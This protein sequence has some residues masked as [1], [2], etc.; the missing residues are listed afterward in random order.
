MGVFEAHKF[1]GQTTGLTRCWC[2][3]PSRKGVT[4]QDVTFECNNVPRRIYRFILPWMKRDLQPQLREYIVLGNQNGSPTSLRWSK[5]ITGYAGMARR[6]C[7]FN[8]R[9]LSSSATAVSKL[10][11]GGCF[12]QLQTLG[13]SVNGSDGWIRSHPV[14]FHTSPLIPGNQRQ[15]AKHADRSVYHPGIKKG[16][17]ITV[18]TPPIPKMGRPIRMEDGI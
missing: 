2:K 15:L 12:L 9:M 5:F 4:E 6:N 16:K 1:D 17:K 13:D 14:V 11:G 18:L 7:S 10:P 8:G 3:V